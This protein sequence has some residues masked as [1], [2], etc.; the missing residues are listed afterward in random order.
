M[1]IYQNKSSQ[2]KIL[3]DNFQL[4]RAEQTNQKGEDGGEKSRRSTKIIRR[5]PAL[6]HCSKCCPERSEWPAHSD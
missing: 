2:N 3:S 1:T 6:Q 5:P 4:K